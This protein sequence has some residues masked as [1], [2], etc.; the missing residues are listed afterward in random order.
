MRDNDIND[1]DERAISTSM[2]LCNSACTKTREGY[3]HAQACETMSDRRSVSAHEA[4]TKLMRSS[5]EAHTKLTVPTV[6]LPAPLP[7]GLCP[8]VRKP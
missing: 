4:H 2:L 7:L 8:V 5:R 3:R 1:D 6:W